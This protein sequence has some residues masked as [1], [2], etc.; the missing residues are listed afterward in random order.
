LQEEIKNLRVENHDLFLKCQENEKN[1]SEVIRLKNEI[2]SLK[3]K[4]KKKSK[5]IKNLKNSKKMSID[6]KEI[7]IQTIK[8]LKDSFN[9]FDFNL[10]G[11]IKSLDLLVSNIK[12]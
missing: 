1:E 11:Q 3:K 2:S 5:T 12:S 6:N 10:Q 7:L 8:N 4:L 9:T